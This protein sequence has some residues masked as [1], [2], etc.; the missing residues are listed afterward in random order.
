MKK[1]SIFSFVVALALVLS[2]GAVLLPTAG[3]VQA[4]GESLQA[5]LDDNGYNIDVTTDELPLKEMFASGVYLVTILDGEH[6]YI[7]PTGW[8]TAGDAGDTHDIFPVPISDGDKEH[9]DSGVADFGF[10]IDSNDGMFYTENAFN[11]DGFDHA[12]VFENTKGPGYLVCF[13]DLWNGGDEDYEDRIIEVARDSD[14]DEVPDELDNCPYVYNPD[15]ADT[16]LDGV[17]DACD[18]CPNVPN[19]GQEDQDNDGVGDVCDNCPADANPDQ[20]D[21]DGDG[22]GDACD[23]CPTDPNKTEPGVCGCGVPDTDTDNDGT[24]DCI[25][26]CPHAPNKPDPGVCGCGVPDT[27]TDNDGTPDC[28]DGCP[29]APTTPE[30]G[31]CGCGVPDTDSD[32]DGTPDCIDNCPDTPNSDQA[33]VDNDGVGDVCDN[34]P[35]VY[36]PDQADSDGDGIGD[37]CEQAQPP[38]GGTI[39]PTDKLGLMMPWIMVGALIV[40]AGVLLAIYNKKLRIERASDR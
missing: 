24:P 12:W 25:D 17:G 39:F 8:N 10:Y 32:N 31:V 21:S 22:T 37:A 40:I 34:C 19:H 30:P 23:G 33:D 26:G 7:N 20:A 15:Q 27:D 9:M 4:A 1:K 5:W 6:G 38:V 13:E 2:L 29:N 35:D 18:N 16:D 11:G 14:E 36:N 3:S 28:I